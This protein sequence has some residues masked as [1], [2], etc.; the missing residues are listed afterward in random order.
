[1]V[2][3]HPEAAAA[4]I[5]N[6]PYLRTLVV[7]E[8]STAEDIGKTTW[9]SAFSAPRTITAPVNPLPK[10]V[11]PTPAT[12]AFNELNL[13]HTTFS[14][15]C[16]PPNSTYNHLYT[17]RSSPLHGPWPENRRESF[18]TTALRGYVPS[19]PMAS[20]LRD[21]ETGHQLWRDASAPADEEGEG[22]LPFILGKP[23]NV[24]HRDRTLAYIKRRE[25]PVVMRS[26]ADFAARCRD[27]AAAQASRPGKDA[28]GGD[29]NAKSKPDRT[30]AAN[31][32][33]KPS[34]DD[35][36]PSLPSID[37][38]LLEDVIENHKE[39]N[40]TGFAARKRR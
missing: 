36:W 6:S 24:Y 38:T 33:S 14:L 39:R 5:E 29:T 30:T 9:G 4:L 17:V 20:A 3:K 28:A 37:E 21:W 13:T 31:G 12:G 35:A 2:T 25:I 15:N 40:R 8:P 19:G 26:L 10:E 16:W 18:L 22:A 23:L 1:M 27:P 7:E 11:E 32:T 34:S